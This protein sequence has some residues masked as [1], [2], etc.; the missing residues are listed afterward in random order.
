MLSALVQAWKD[1]ASATQHC[2]TES[3]QTANMPGPSP[4]AGSPA[5]QA[6]GAQAAAASF[7]TQTVKKQKRNNSGAGE[8][9]EGSVPPSSTQSTVLLPAQE[10]EELSGQDASPSQPAS[11]RARTEDDAQP[12]TSTE[13]GVH[14]DEEASHASARQVGT[15]AWV[16][17]FGVR[18]SQLYMSGASSNEVGTWLFFCRRRAGAS[19]ARRMTGSNSSSQVLCFL[20]SFSCFSGRLGKRRA[21]KEGQRRKPWCQDQQQPASSSQGTAHRA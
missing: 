3:A 21:G 18:G 11:K 1:P 14:G 4:A 13:L 7:L 10:P 16:A 17:L 8:G 19:M 6:C 20:L 2:M 15:P 12:S 9:K 5:L